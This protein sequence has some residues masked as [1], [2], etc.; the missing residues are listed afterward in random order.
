MKKLEI[1]AFVL[2]VLYAVSLISSPLYTVVITRVYGSEQVGQLLLH[3]HA[4]LTVWRLLM[5]PVHIAVAVWL[6]LQAK[7]DGLS[8]PIWALFGLFFSVLGAVL[9][10]VIRGQRENS[11]T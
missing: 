5:V 7:R 1:L 8:W 11:A 3:Q 10:F 9:Y 4:M 6:G 2:V